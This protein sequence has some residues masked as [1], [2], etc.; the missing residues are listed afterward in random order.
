MCG[1]KTLKIVAVLIGLVMVASAVMFFSMSSDA[2]GPMSEDCYSYSPTF[3]FSG[4]DAADIRWDFGDGTILDSRDVLEDGYA[5]LLAAHGGNVWA[6]KHTYAD[7]G[8]VSYIDYVVVQTVY[9]S[10]EGGSEDSVTLYIRMYGHPVITIM[11]GTDIINSIEVPKNVNYTPNA[12]TIPSVPVLDGYTFGGYFTDSE[13]TSEYVWTTPVASDV[14]LYTKWTVA[15]TP[16]GPDDD[17]SGVEDPLMDSEVLVSVGMLALGILMIF[18]GMKFVDSRDVKAAFV[19]FG[20]IAVFAGS[21][22][23][24]GHVM[25]IDFVEEFKILIGLSESE[26]PAGGIDE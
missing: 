20:V 6:P 18:G 25:D 22:L 14:T 13:L 8:D 4:A 19:T 21:I 2:D 23:L 3:V 5:E 17:G 24:Y 9:N 26:V 11:N 10:F 12:A 7:N 15:T 1:D 16:V